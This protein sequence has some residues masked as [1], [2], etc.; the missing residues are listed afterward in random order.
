MLDL[1]PLACAGAGGGRP[2][3][4]VRCCSWARRSPTASTTSPMTK[5]AASIV[6][7][8]EQLGRKRYPNA[9]IL[10]ITADC[11][12]STGNRTRLGN[13]G[14]VLLDQQ[15]ATAARTAHPAGRERLTRLQLAHPKPDR[16]HVHPRRPRRRRDPTPA[17]RARLR[18]RPQAALS[19]IQLPA[20]ALNRSPIAS[21]SIPPPSSSLAVRRAGSRRL[22]REELLL[23][24]S[25]N[26]AHRSTHRSARGD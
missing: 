22:R 23:D 25:Q 11:G 6:G 5:A 9:T 15:P 20:N 12:G 18:R 17:I 19:F 2:G 10:T 3:S 26:G 21:S 24:R 1:V 13:Q 14:R 16:L 8:W 4:A 7:W